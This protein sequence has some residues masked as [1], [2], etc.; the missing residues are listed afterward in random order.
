MQMYQ[1]ALEEIEAI[2]IKEKLLYFA[3]H[4]QTVSL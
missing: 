3:Q 2:Q 4:D 1:E